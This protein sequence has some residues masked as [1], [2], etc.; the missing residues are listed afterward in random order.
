MDRGLWVGGEHEADDAVV[1]DVGVWVLVDA[2]VSAEME[3]V[4]QRQRGGQTDEGGFE[5]AAHQKPREDGGLG[6]RGLTL[7]RRHMAY[8]FLRGR[9]GRTRT[10]DL[11]PSCTR[12]SLTNCPR[13]AGGN[14]SIST[15]I[16]PGRSIGS[17]PHSGVGNSRK[18]STAPGTTEARSRTAKSTRKVTANS[19]KFSSR[20][21]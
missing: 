20:S 11:P 18:G 9:N 5:R 2:S 8:V 16:F 14:F 12:G 13:D 7:G 19:T 4:G 3:S 6:R 21:Q 10:S 15:S 1:G 17:W